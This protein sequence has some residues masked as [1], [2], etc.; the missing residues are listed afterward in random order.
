MARVIVDEL[1][2]N[3]IDLIVLSPGSRSGALAIA[4]AESRATTRVLIDE[5]SAAFWGLGRAKATG[6]PAAVVCTSGTAPANFLPAVVEADMSLTPLVLISADRPAEMI[7][8]GANQTIDQTDLFGD[9]VRFAMTVEAPTAHT[10]GNATWRAAVSAAVNAAVGSRGTPGP[11]HL[12]V[13]FREPTVPVSDDGRSSSPVFRHSIQ[14]RSGGAP[15]MAPTHSQPPLPVTAIPARERGLVLAGD[16]SYDRPGLL[17]AARSVGWPVVATALS[18]L[19]GEDVVSHYHYALAGG[20]PPGLRPQ[21][22]V[23]VGAVGPSQRLEGL[24]ASADSRYRVDRLGR[25]IDPGRNSTAL[26][27]ADPVALLQSVDGGVGDPVWNE[28]WLEADRA[29]G[30]SVANYLADMSESTGP[31]VA[32]AMSRCD[33][34]TL[35]VASSLPIRDVDSHLNRSGMVIG[36]RGASGID[37]FVSTALGVAS[38]GSP[39]LALTGDLSLFHDSNGFLSDRLE[40]LVIIVVDNNGG[41]LFDLLPQARHAPEFERLFVAPP[42]RRVADVARLHDLHYEEIGS[43]GELA[44]SVAGARS[45]AGVSVLHIPVDREQDLVTRRSLDRV[46]SKAASSVE[47]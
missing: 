11:V 8:I 29:V 27:H 28:R 46:G 39:T 10:D 38:A 42:G 16:G 3:G 7:G 14:G 26:V 21:V 41:G 25:T 13:A 2:R 5:R 31:G 37:G 33:W 45:R 30:R 6:V 23:A 15:W 32:D 35:V 34:D 43:P 47:A 4:A 20:V 44:V 22:V 36:N 40:D 9:R 18:G 12:N 19:R 17:S 1:E 24:I